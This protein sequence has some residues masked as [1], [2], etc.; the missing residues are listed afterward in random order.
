M[1]RWDILL[2]FTLQ[3]NIFTFQE[4][5]PVQYCTV[6]NVPLRKLRRPLKDLKRLGISKEV[7]PQ[8]SVNN[9]PQA[10]VRNGPEQAQSL[11]RKG[12]LHVQQLVRNRPLRPQLFN[13]EGPPHLQQLVRDGP[14]Q[15]QSLVR[16]VKPQP[17]VRNAPLPRIKVANKP[18]QF[19]FRGK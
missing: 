9:A 14:L 13:T 1:L 18:K 3:T 4:L 11:V 16:N 2:L 12:K 5:V 8:T 10:L 17:L 15:P 6:P 19:R 7:E